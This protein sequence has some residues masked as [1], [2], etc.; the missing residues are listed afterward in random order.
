MFTSTTKKEKRIL[1]FCNW[2]LKLLRINL[3]MIYL[4]LVDVFQSNK[5]Q[6]IIRK[7]KKK[8]KKT[9]RGII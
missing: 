5:I 9:Y 7:K 6:T 3:T 1:K 2:N 4:Y 8:R